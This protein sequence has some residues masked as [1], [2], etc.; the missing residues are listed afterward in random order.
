MK[1]KYASGYVFMATSLDGFVARQDNTLDWLMKYGVDE[2]DTSF[3]TFTENMDVLVMGSGTFKTVI[4]FD[5][6]PYTMPTFVMSRTL[7]QD[8]VPES[9]QAKVTINAL[10]PTELMQFLFQQ[11]FEN[12]Y[13]D[14]GKLVQS[15]LGDGLISEITLTQIPILI[16]KGKRLFGETEKDI[17]MELI[18]SKS[19]KFGFLQNHYRVLNR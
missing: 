12:V 10:D 9:L 15:F 2:S 1:D 8:D 6:W 3:A 16:G 18:S 7:T 14:G 17:D 4:G 11:G 13:V 5:Q 19:M